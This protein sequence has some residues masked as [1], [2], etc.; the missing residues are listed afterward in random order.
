MRTTAVNQRPGSQWASVLFALLLGL[1]LAAGLATTGRAQ[2][3]TGSIRGRVVDASGAVIPGAAVKITNSSTG[4]TRTLVTQ[5]NGSFV[6]SLLPPGTYNVVITKR[7]FKSFT[8][9]AVL[10]HSAATYVVTAT[11]Q[12]GAVTQ[13]VQ[14]KAAPIQIDK[15]TMQLGGELA[16]T[17]VTNFPLLNLNWLNLQQTLPGVM[18]SSDRF[19]TFST[20]G[21]RTQSNDYMINGM[22]AN[23]LPLNTPEGGGVNPLNPDAIQEV[24]VVDSTTNPEYGRNSGAIENVVTR[25]GTNQFHGSM[26][27]Y[28]RSTGFNARTFFQPTTSPYHQHQFGATIGGPVLHNRVFFFFGY[29]GVRLFQGGSA[30]TPVFSAAQRSGNWSGALAHLAGSDVSPF[31]LYGD[32]KSTC[33]VGSSQ[34]PA[35]TPYSQLFSTGIVPAQ[36]FNP[37]AAALMNKYVPLPNTPEGTYA[38]SNNS[39]FTSDQY[40]GRMD[41]HPTSSDSAFFFFFVQ[42]LSGSATLPFTG[43]TLPGFGSTT[44]QNFYRYTLDETHI[45]NSRMVNDFRIGWQRFHFIA[46]N[47]QTPTLPSSAGFTGITPQDP[48]GAGLPVVNVL[49]YFSLGFSR[50][51]PQPRVDDT[52]ELSDNLSYATG[53][54][55]FRFGADIR[56]STVFNPFFFLNSGNFGFQGSGT[57]TTGLPG[58]DFLLGIPDSYGQSSGGVINARTWL[59]YSYLQ[60]Q[61]QVK[62]DLTLTYGVGWQID[63]PLTDLY[64]KGVAINA[65]NPA[66]Q[67]TV[68]PTAPRGLLFPGDTGINSSGGVVTHFNNFGPRFGFAYNPIQKLVIRGGWG[69][70]YDN[71]EEELTLQNLLAPPFS[72]I[73]SGVGD[74]GLSPS[75]TQPFSSVNSV[76]VCLA[77]CGGST[78]VIEP[79]GS[80]ANKYPFTPPAPGA[81]VDFSFFEPLSLNVTQPNFNLPYVM[82]MNLTTQYQINPT[83]VATISYV[84]SLGRKLEGTLEANPYN[85]QTYIQDCNPTGK[86]PLVCERQRLFAPLL[87]PNIGTVA[88]ANIFASVGTQTT[89]LTSN[90][91]SLQVSIEKAMS[92]GLYIR[93]AYTYGHALDY[94]SSYENSNGLVDPYNYATAYGDS[95]YDARQR[96]VIE[97]QYNIPNWSFGLLPRR[98]TT[99]WAFSGI[100]TFQTGFPVPLTESDGRSYQ[101]S[102]LFT[103]YGCWNRPQVT[104]TPVQNFS[105]PRTSL[106]HEWFNPSAY[107]PENFGTFGN[108]GR[109]LP[110]HGPGINNWDVS[111]WKN[112]ALA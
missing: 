62:R 7:G 75:F 25:S 61:W 46:V 77:G 35:G 102:P 23:D 99:G 30:N 33:P 56:R 3:I 63:T 79:S 13:T 17:Q 96:L 16:G 41:F 105:N 112:T 98:L 84:G 89:F 95:T 8:Q 97:Y 12:V 2:G 21:S 50:N 32:S 48:A 4:L 26:Y 74:I 40:L 45:I 90:Y 43:A 109:N 44:H 78:P 53:A 34:C 80:I 22:D 110:F 20:N 15:T 103:F 47:P 52:G 72:L 107:A 104:G 82:N 6:A 71:S 81:P 101:C 49:G 94:G 66:R 57:F 64:N 54:H 55:D 1:L 31:P 24:K 73:D 19:G 42:P 11:L 37:V 9:A 60:D 83:T 70:Y 106:K 39:S 91:N 76:P 68:F 69:I 87:Y 36:D 51:G 67:S 29:Q 65:F 58:V 14:V 85:A 10:L 92:H 38:F 108:A 28:Y 111:F 18:A 93:G 100:T 86:T 88:P 27:D 59:I 5:A